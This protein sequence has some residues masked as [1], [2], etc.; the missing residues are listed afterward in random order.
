[1]TTGMTITTMA[2]GA[3]QNSRMR[4]FDAY[5]MVD[6]SAASKPVTGKNSI[7][8]AVGRQGK[9]GPDIE[10][11]NF[12]TRSAAIAEIK[13]RL[14]DFKTRKQ[15]VL[16][17]WD[18]PHGYPR[19]FAR[20]LGLDGTPWLETWRFLAERS[21][22]LD[23]D[24]NSNNRFEIAAALNRKHFKAGF[25]FWGHPAGREIAGLMPTKTP[26]FGQDEIAERRLVETAPYV[27]KAKSV[28]QLAYN[29]SVGSQALLGIP[30]VHRLRHDR[31]LA[32]H[33]TIW[34]FETGLRALTRPA[35]AAPWIV[36]AEIYPSLWSSR[37]KPGPGQTLDE[38]QVR[39]VV[40]LL[41][42]RDEAGALPRMFAGT[43]DLS[44]AERRS[45]EQEEGWI[46]GV[47]GKLDYERDPQA[48]Y[49]R[50]FATIAEETDFSR[51]PPDMV[52]IAT[53]LIH[54]C[55]MT[56]V[57]DD[58]AW[59][60]DAAAAGRQALARGAPILVDSRM[61]EAGIIAARLKGGNHIVCTL[62]DKGVDGL[63]RKRG[64]TRSAAAVEKW[65][66][67]LAGAV[68]AIGNAPTALFRLLE[69]LDD[70]ADRPAVILGFPVGFVGA[71]E[72]KAAL[73]ADPRGVPF[74][75]LRGR[76]GGSAMAA[77]AVNALARPETE[78]G[79]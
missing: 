78:D 71:A 7:W 4:Q 27:A 5:V 43:A 48:I 40:S 3:I 32:P 11:A 30:W 31:D 47:T 2:T 34:P 20:R 36:H 26:G 58:L 6:W 13:R 76:R 21:D 77:A 15:S 25:P 49:R 53:R 70:G 63:A 8:Y 79:A 62:R 23:R 64:T 24:D 1:M 69:L 74:I 9:A 61:V 39:A 55:G 19:G 67:R 33:S 35:P 16:V 66:A 59:S 75:T 72:A 52:A 29:G 10:T 68:V 37:I 44:A 56:D 17:G 41:A 60:A 22:L 73:E 46:F 57:V 42:E 50:S 38:A 51:L 65:R 45:V 12:A 54:A 28:W 18:F 14:L